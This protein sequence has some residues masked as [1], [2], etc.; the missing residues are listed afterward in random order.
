MAQDVPVQYFKLNQKGLAHFFGELEAKLMEAVWTLDKPSVQDV[1][2]YWAGALNY[3]TVLTVLNRLVEKGL[4]ERFKSGR[5]FVY[6]ATSTREKLLADVFD[7]LVRGMFDGDFRQIALV[8]MI[9]TADEIDPKILN[10]MTCLI[11][12]K[13][14]KT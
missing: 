1:V 4:L 6:T 7:Q 13:R 2:D 11:E 9:E 8:Q 10:D 5:V 12:Q 3:K 14:S